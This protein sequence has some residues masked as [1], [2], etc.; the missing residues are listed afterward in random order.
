MSQE[1]NLLFSD[2]PDLGAESADSVKLPPW[3]VL[4]VDDDEEVHSATRYALRQALILGRPLA[5]V[6]TYS[7]QATR[8]LLASDRDFAL[9]LLDVVMESE[10]AGLELVAHIREHCGMTACRII[11]RTGQPGYAPEA[12]VFNS[13]DIND[14][15]S[16]AELGQERLIISL[17]AA[18]R[19][20]VQ[21]TRCMAAE[22]QALDSAAE[23]EGRV[24]TRTAEL[25]LARDAAQAATRAKSE[26]L[27]NMS[28]EIRTPMN[29]IIGMTDLALLGSDLSAKQRRYLATTKLAA[30]ALLSIINDVLDFS[31]IEAGHLQLEEAEFSLQEMFDRVAAVIG[32]RAQDKGLEL[33]FDCAADVPQR[34]RGD[35]LRLA[36]VL[37]NLCGNAL[38]FSDSG[39]ILVLVERVEA[40]E[41]L[42]APALKLRFRVRDQGIGMSAAQMAALFQPF[43]QAD[44]SIT[45]KFGGTG[46]GLAI[47]KQLVELMSGSFAV[48]SE[49]GRGSE[50]SF[51]VR[52]AVCA[53][54]APFEPADA[55]LA[56]LRVLVIDDSLNSRE[57]LQHR[58]ESLGLRP[59]LADSARAGIA[60]LQMAQ[61]AGQAFDLLLLDWR[62]PD[63]DGL[64]AAERL[65]ALG[66]V[67]ARQIILVTAFDAH[68]LQ[69]AVER[70]QLAGCL[71][72]PVSE[73]TL[74]EA[75][76]QAI[77]PRPDQPALD[78]AA[79]ERRAA[80]PADP[81][82]AG[83]MAGLRGRHVLLVEDNDM[84]QMLAC[85]LLQE[86]AG[87][88]VRVAGNGE[89]ALQWLSQQ[90]FDLVL[91]DVQMPV[92]DGLQATR[93]IRQDARLAGLPVIAM[94][95]QVMSGDRARCAAAGMND[96]VSKP[97]LAQELFTTLAKWLPAALPAAR[98][99]QA[100]P[101]VEG[102]QA[103][104]MAGLAVLDLDKALGHCQGRAELL[105]KFMHKFLATR[106][107]DAQQMLAAMQAGD[108]AQ[109]ARIAHTAISTAAIIG[110]DRLSAVARELEA[111]LLAVELG[112]GA[113]EGAA[114][115]RFLLQQ[116]EAQLLAVQAALRVACVGGP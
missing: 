80:A 63:M 114:D 94:T 59:A 45:R 19:A 102:A 65:Q 78:G 11:L 30:D 31:K 6:H 64:Q 22:A 33:L 88:Q 43:Q 113:V 21:I 55:G 23:L 108:A 1:P 41:L 15:R 57:I 51:E 60:A 71:A 87:M 52:L 54:P 100:E 7:A 18:L 32:L 61:L 62:M 34:V 8:E 48:R 66:L 50:F 24:A 98:A 58:L 70:M 47:C 16:K 46:L 97:V 67:Q 38:K 35:A 82:E 39:E 96:Y 111:S 95:A 73:R 81:A 20:H 107:G 5:L 13:Y 72:K 83:L 12:D 101:G 4:V 29:A 26:F 28:H 69:P 17:S 106:L 92:M 115:W 79:A 86:L 2:E 53:E 49:L 75:I 90:N 116:F 76:G 3:R 68:A 9:I 25:A 37:I 84:N 89:E 27:A 42:D 112:E 14:Y 93:L 99:A 74:R 104:K 44:S 10:R 91:M 109:A 85:E 103:Q 56:G 77:G 36:Q 40:P 110:A 105:D